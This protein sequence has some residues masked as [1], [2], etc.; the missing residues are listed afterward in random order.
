[1][2]KKFCNDLNLNKNDYFYFSC[3]ILFGILLSINI[4][5]FN[6]LRGAFN[7]DVY[8]YL[9]NSLNFAGMN[10][11]NLSDPYWMF[12]APLICYLTSLLFKIGY[13]NINAIFIVT[14]FFSIL[15]ILASYILLKVKF[16]SLLSFTGA[17]L[18]SSL[19]ITLF[20]FS[21]GM[22]DVPAVSMMMWVL[23]FTIAAVDKNPKYYILV[24]ISFV[25]AFNIRFTSTYIIL[26]VLLYMLK[27]YDLVDLLDNLISDKTQFKESILTFLYSSDFKWMLYSLILGIILMF[28][29]FFV[30][31]SYGGDLYFL[32]HASSSISGLHANIN[33]PNVITDRWF[34]IKNFLNFLSCNHIV[35]NERMVEFFIEPSWFAYLICSIL[36]GGILLKV[37]NLIKNRNFV[38]NMFI[39]RD[40]YK[41]KRFEVV[42]LLLFFVLLIVSRYGFRHNYIIGVFGLFMCF[43]ILLSLSNKF[44][45]NN[46]FFAFSI[47]NLALFS[48]F[49]FIFSYMNIKCIRYILPAI[50]GFIYFVVYA[51]EY[52]INIFDKG[53][54]VNENLLTSKR[55]I[56]YKK[57][58]S[59][60]IPIALILICLI[61]ICNY[62][63]TVEIAEKGNDIV[64]VCDFIVKYDPDYQSKDMASY[65]DRYF[66]WYLN[67]DLRLT[68]DSWRESNYTYIIYPME[69]K[70][71][72]YHLIYNSSDILVYEH[73]Y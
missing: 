19:S 31:W 70:D 16:S 32:N 71:K 26:V 23:I 47:I 39:H 27:K 73:N 30:I 33:D 9:L 37:I 64:E 28:Y 14:G 18:Y 67:K 41:T 6:Q 52:I 43:C 58:A 44:K 51:L 65:I 68:T 38:K 66:E 24:C 10:Y 63:N 11:N 49:L 3:L 36:L 2:I 56:K 15:G 40:S 60:L 29:G 50:P 20:W 5:H 59:K 17:I 42:L 45:I 34:Y 46:N 1:M 54:I 62:T 48:F 12:C 13:V 8:V 25:L 53:F 35:F 4:I 72:N 55:D 21:N 57:F 69:L 7:S 22:L 61:V